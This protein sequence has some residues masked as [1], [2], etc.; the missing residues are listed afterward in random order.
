MGSFDEEG[1]KG[2]NNQ[3]I[4]GMGLGEKQ[5]VEGSLLEEML[6]MMVEKP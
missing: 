4:C 1:L 5:S 3:R 2:Q 6:E